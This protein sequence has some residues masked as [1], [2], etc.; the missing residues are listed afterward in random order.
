[1]SIEHRNIQD[2]QIHEPRGVSTATVGQVYVA[3]GLGSG[4]WGL[5]QIEGQAGA[6]EGAIPIRTDVGVSWAIN[7]VGNP[8]YA[9]IDRAED[10]VSLTQNVEVKLGGFDFDDHTSDNFTLTTNSDLEINVSGIYFVDYRV[11]VKPS[12]SLGGSSEEL[13]V[14]LKKNGDVQ[15]PFREGE[16]TI[17]RNSEAGDPFTLSNAR[18]ISLNASDVLTLHLEAEDT[19][20]SYGVQAS[21]QIFK[22]ANQ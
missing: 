18:I 6:S 9:E 19:S 14:S 16:I 10:T 15:V 13:K 21:I 8:C 20:R 2:P 4:S 17:T 12:T 5:A 11:K 7:Q 22:I 3:D 1:M